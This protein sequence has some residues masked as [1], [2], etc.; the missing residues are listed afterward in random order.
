MLDDGAVPATAWARLREREETLRVG[1]DSAPA[2]LRAGHRRRSGLRT[3]SVADG[4]GRLDLD[5]HAHLHPLERVLEGNADVGLEVV[6]A[7]RL[8][9]RRSPASTEHPTEEVAQVREIELLEP[10]AA[11]VGAGVSTGVGGSAVRVVG[12]AAPAAVQIDAGLLPLA[13]LELQPRRR[14]GASI[15]QAMVFRRSVWQRAFSS[16]TAARLA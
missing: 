5:G 14:A 2:A 9:A 3:R 16:R 6:P 12:L 11:H 7:N 15:S 8:P 4:A 1:D 10:H 13:D